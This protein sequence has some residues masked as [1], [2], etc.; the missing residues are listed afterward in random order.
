M[1]NIY[2][3]LLM[4]L[5]SYQLFAG[6]DISPEENAPI[7]NCQSFDDSNFFDM[8][9][10]GYQ[11]CCSHHRGICGCGYGGYLRCCDGTTSPSC[12]C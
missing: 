11:G 2:V 6:N 9:R 4:L 10:K 5:F 8:K 12:R 7:L 3:L 1:K